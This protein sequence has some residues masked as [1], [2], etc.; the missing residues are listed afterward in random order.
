MT[1]TKKE[2]KK[3]SYNDP[4]FTNCRNPVY[5]PLAELKGKYDETKF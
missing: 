1:M 2:R 4:T 3:L 5:I